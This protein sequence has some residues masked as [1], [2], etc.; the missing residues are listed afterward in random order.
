M[1]A[2]CPNGTRGVAEAPSTTAAGQPARSARTASAWSGQEQPVDGESVRGA[3]DD[4]VQP[5][6]PEDLQQDSARP[7]RRCRAG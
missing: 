1:S 3:L 6:A 4:R 7:D 2:S 5:D